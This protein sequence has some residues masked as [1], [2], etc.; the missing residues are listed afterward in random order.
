MLVNTY[1]IHFNGSHAVQPL[2]ARSSLIVAYAPDIKPIISGYRWNFEVDLL[3]WQVLGLCRGLLCF[4]PFPPFFA[5]VL[6]FCW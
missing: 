5:L 4:E 2:L 1:V 6:T 3:S